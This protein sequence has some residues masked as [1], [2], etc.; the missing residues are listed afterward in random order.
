MRSSYL[1]A[2]AIAVSATGWI[3]SGQIPALG[4]QAETAPSPSHSAAADAVPVTTVRAAR[5]SARPIVNAVS[6]FGHTQAARRVTLRAQIDGAVDEILVERGRVVTIGQPILRIDVE[7]RDARVEQAVAML[8]L[9]EKEYKAA[10]SL[11]SR[12]FNSEIRMVE[13]MALREAARA[14][15]ARA[16]IALEQTLIS[17]P[18]DGVLEQ[19]PVELGDF[20]DA[21][22]PV[23]TVVDLDPIKLVGQVS[24]RTVTQIRL[25]QKAEGRLVTGQRVGGTVSYVSATAEQATRTFRVE[26]DVP[27]PDGAILEGVTAQLLLP[28]QER[29]AH[30]VS[31]SVLSL[32]DDGTLGVKLVTADDRVRFHAVTIVRDDKD[33]IWLSGLPTQIGLITVGHEFVTDGARVVV[34]WDDAAELAEGPP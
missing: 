30:F 14:E 25:G 5:L 23:A 2:A 33:G 3:V 31:P 26:I 34:A 11:S 18:F 32:D 9:R 28:L 16:R 13:T 6:L 27:N 22:D 29:L 19:R 24:E 7:D 10:D 8:A 4:D 12:G 20:V 1:I 15:L 17:T 21:G